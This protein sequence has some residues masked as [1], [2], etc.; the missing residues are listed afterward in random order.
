ME[1]SAP[2]S[3]ATKPD[4]LKTVVSPYSRVI[5]VKWKHYRASIVVDIQRSG[6][7]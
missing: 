4:W 6:Q 1:I 5:L 2:A 3:Q 7:K